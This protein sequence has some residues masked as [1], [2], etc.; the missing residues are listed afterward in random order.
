MDELEK[1]KK[2]M[3][4]LEDLAEGMDERDWEDM[5]PIEALRI[6]AGVYEGIGWFWDHGF[7][8][9]PDEIKN[10]AVL[11]AIALCREEV[12]RQ[13][14]HAADLLEGKGLNL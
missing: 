4:K 12:A 2:L 11:A 3:A 8:D 10:M 1:T 13:M 6:V 7:K 9:A 5:S 14:T